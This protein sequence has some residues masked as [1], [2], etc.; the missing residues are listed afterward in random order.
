MTR[1]SAE[2]VGHSIWGYGVFAHAVYRINVSHKQ[3]NWTIYRRFSEFASLHERLTA[4]NPTKMASIAE[5][6]PEKEYV[7]PIYSSMEHVVAKRMAALQRY[8]R[9][10]LELE[11]VEDVEEVGKFFD[12]QYKGISGLRYLIFT[13]PIE[14][15]ILSGNPS[16][17]S[18]PTL[19]ILSDGVYY[20][21]PSNVATKIS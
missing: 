19:F 1:L 21:D 6:M 16:V 17:N 13:K 18:K 9:G 8:L 3:D 4:I 20:R 7:G 11:H 2:V 15:N 5:F 12:F 14:S 10:L